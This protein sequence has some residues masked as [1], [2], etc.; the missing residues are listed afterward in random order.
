MRIAR[1][2]SLDDATIDE[3]R[4]VFVRELTTR[5]GATCI[6]QPPSHVWLVW[7]TSPQEHEPDEPTIQS[8]HLSEDGADEAAS[9]SHWCRVEKLEVRP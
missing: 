7:Y 8:A 5:T 6:A 9:S 1:G 2:L 4:K 3:M